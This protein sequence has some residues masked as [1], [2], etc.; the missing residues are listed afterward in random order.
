LLPGGARI[1]AEMEAYMKKKKYEQ[2]TR[3]QYINMVKNNLAPFF[4]SFYAKKHIPIL[5]DT[6]LFA[7]EAGTKI[8]PISEYLECEDMEPGK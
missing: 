2:R 4:E 7:L 6:L 5:M 3:T 8:P 1:L